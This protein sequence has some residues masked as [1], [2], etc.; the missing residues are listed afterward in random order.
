MLNPIGKKREK[1]LNWRCGDTDWIISTNFNTV[2]HICAT[3]TGKYE[4]GENTDD[5]IQLYL[6]ENFVKY[7]SFKPYLTPRKGITLQKDQFSSRLKIPL[8]PSGSNL[9]IEQEQWYICDL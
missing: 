7:L 1:V 3:L 4:L 8:Q 9:L 2:F 6:E 5:Q